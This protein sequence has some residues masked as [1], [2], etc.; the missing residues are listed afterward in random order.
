MLH[1]AW[2]DHCPNVV[3]EA[4]AQGC[5]VICSSEGGT[6][7]LVERAGG[8][9][10]PDAKPYSFD[11]VDYDNPPRVPLDGLTLS[12]RIVVDKNTV[13]IAKTAD[14]YAEV[15]RSALNASR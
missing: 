12:E 2:L 3:V 14:S 9:V 13:D 11:L 7:E 8:I 6:R 1:L 10:V 5:P 15:L 4:L